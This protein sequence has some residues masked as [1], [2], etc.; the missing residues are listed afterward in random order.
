VNDDDTREAD[1][2]VQRLR[3]THLSDVQSAEAWLLAHPDEAEPALI[4]ALDTPAAQPAAVLLGM[5]GRPDGIAPLVAAHRRG[6]QGLR[7]AVE[8]ALALYA[9]PEAAAALA[10]LRATGESPDL[11]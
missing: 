2:A 11:G 10:S 4:A 3:S 5:I 6:G 8:R 7:A 9:S 1:H